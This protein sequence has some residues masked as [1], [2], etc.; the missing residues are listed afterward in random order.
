MIVATPTPA[1]STTQNRAY[2]SSETMPAKPV[3]GSR[4]LKCRPFET[5]IHWPTATT[6]P[7]M[8]PAAAIQASTALRAT[9]RSTRKTTRAPTATTTPGRIT[10]LLYTSDAADDLLCVD[11]GG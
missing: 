2:L 6:A 11:L 5:L 4:A 1:N 7:T 8:S 10:C 3:C 9:N